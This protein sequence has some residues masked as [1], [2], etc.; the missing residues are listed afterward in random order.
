MNTLVNELEKRTLK[1]LNWDYYVALVQKRKWTCVRPVSTLVT[2]PSHP[3]ASPNWSSPNI[4]FFVSV[5]AR[6]TRHGAVLPHLHFQSQSSS[7]G[8]PKPWLFTCTPPDL[9]GEHHGEPE[10]AAAT[11]TILNPGNPPSSCDDTSLSCL[12]PHFSVPN[13]NQH[14]NQL[15][16]L[17]MSSTS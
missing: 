8:E 6:E 11:A 17:S 2:Q 13:Q 15:A 14:Q 1:S 9:A 10:L 3:T 4:F 16:H 12:L 5:C 7:Q